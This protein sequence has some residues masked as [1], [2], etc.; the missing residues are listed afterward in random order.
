LEASSSDP[1]GKKFDMDRYYME[2]PKSPRLMAGDYCEQV[3]CNLEGL[4]KL[5]GTVEYNID[6]STLTDLFDDTDYVVYPNQDLLDA[7]ADK[8]SSDPE[9]QKLINNGKAT[10]VQDEN[11]A[12]QNQV[13]QSN[14]ANTIKYGMNAIEWPF[15]NGGDQGVGN[16][17]MP[18][19]IF[20]S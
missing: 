6:P 13:V 12:V 10:S 4:Q 16:L 3:E 17:D 19:E 11:Q 18:L 8:L 2:I 7:L 20:E 5:L 15:G 9:P 14:D 1:L